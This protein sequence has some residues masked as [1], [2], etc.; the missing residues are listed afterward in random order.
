MFLHRFTVKPG[1]LDEYLE[2]WRREVEVR[3]RHGFV[4]HQAFVETDAEP[5]ISWL[6]SHAEPEP[7]EAAV[8]GDLEGKEI[9]ALKRDLVFRNTK[10]RPVDV[11]VIAERVDTPGIVIM[12][13]YSIVG[14][15]AEFLSI[16]R[17]IV[18]VRARHGFDCMFA[19]AD[20]PE[21]MFT[22]A[23]TFDGDWE[24]FAAAQRPYYRDPDRVALRGVFDHMADYSIH[25]ARRLVVP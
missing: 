25:P 13:R 7:A 20:R 9:D 11:E 8:L 17:R 1:H 10:V 16:W 24:D 22:W 15:W 23:F 19:V 2:V 21:N 3:R 12:R 14:S 18:P 5:K 6:Y 4:T